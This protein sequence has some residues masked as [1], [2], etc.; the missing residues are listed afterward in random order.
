MSQKKKND[1]INS[2]TFASPKIFRNYASGIPTF[3]S[4]YPGVQCSIATQSHWKLT[5]A[6]YF[7]NLKPLQFF[8]NP[9][10]FCHLRSTS[11]FAKISVSPRIHE[12]YKWLKIRH[13]IS[14]LKFVVGSR[15]KIKYIPVSVKAMKKASPICKQP[16][17]DMSI[18]FT[19]F[20]VET[21][22]GMFS[23]DLCQKQYLNPLTSENYN[24]K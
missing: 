22:A 11:T 16:P 21:M 9:R 12:T 8:N 10:C 18:I 14:F 17:Q 24:E 15:K 20:K 19:P 5:T 13:F 2:V 6:E 23:V 1:K 3:L 7:F 4:T